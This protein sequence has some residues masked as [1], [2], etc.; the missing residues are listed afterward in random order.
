MD[1]SVAPPPYVNSFTNFYGIDSE[2]KDVISTSCR[3]PYFD[4]IHMNEIYSGVDESS[5][6]SNL[7]CAKYMARC[8]FIDQY[9]NKKDLDKYI[10]D[11]IPWYQIMVYNILY[12]MR[13]V[14]LRSN[15]NSIAILN[16]N[17][18][19]VKCKFKSLVPETRE[20][21]WAFIIALSEYDPNPPGNNYTWKGINKLIMD[22]VNNGGFVDGLVFK[23]VENST[24]W[25]IF[26][27][28]ASALY[29]NKLT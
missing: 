9:K 7:K 11:R 26:N 18:E 3:F 12:D 5:C 2:W 19:L 6:Y 21:L 16:E 8:T 28:A 25:N 29:T 22:A 1:N 14:E 27:K 4:T 15:E 10:Y 23:S 20:N 17:R 24:P 13:L